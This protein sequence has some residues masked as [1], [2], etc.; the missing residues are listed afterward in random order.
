[1]FK[2]MLFHSVSRTFLFLSKP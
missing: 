1:M 2:K